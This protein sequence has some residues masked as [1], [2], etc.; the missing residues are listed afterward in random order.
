[1]K[2]K[3]IVKMERGACFDYIGKIIFIEDIHFSYDNKCSQRVFLSDETGSENPDYDLICLE[4]T[5]N[6]DDVDFFEKALAQ[7]NVKI[8]DLIFDG[9]NKNNKLINVHWYE[10]SH[11]TILSTA[12]KSKY[13]KSEDVHLSEEVLLKLNN[14]IKCLLT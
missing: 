3:E 8:R 6:V 2:I 1:M 9:E 14:K 7:A 5:G 12:A 10:F 4:L 13:H 11:R